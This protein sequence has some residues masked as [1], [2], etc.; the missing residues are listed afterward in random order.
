M[1]KHALLAA[2][3]VVICAVSAGTF[4]ANNAAA[5]SVTDERTPIDT[6]SYTCDEGRTITAAYFEGAEMPAESGEMPNPQG[7]VEVSLD[8]GASMTLQQTVSAS[9]I[10]YAN[11]DESFVFWSKGDE[12]LIMRENSMDLTYQNC[13]AS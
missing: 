5:P 1:R 8:G 9:G 7:S 12:A 2:I 13:T 6:V 11:E 4:F 10:R 3:V